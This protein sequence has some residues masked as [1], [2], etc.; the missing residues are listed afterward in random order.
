MI[1]VKKLREQGMS[2]D[3]IEAMFK[4]ECDL[5]DDAEEAAAA[6]DKA[7][8]A[9]R[10]ARKDMCDAIIIYFEALGHD[11]IADERDRLEDM[12]IECE[13]LLKNLKVECGDGKIKIRG[14]GF[15]P[16]GFG[17]RWM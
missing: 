6:K 8:N 13:D 1:D 4:N 17:L 14:L 16:L 5:V 3:E 10:E 2:W 12:F 9:I 11:G 15:N 7:N